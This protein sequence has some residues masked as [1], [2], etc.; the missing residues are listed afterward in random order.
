MARQ[1]IGFS[2][3]AESL[4]LYPWAWALL[5]TANVVQ[6]DREGMVKACAPIEKAVSLK[7]ND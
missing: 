7:P 4:E 2:E 6:S 1:A 3:Q 5:G